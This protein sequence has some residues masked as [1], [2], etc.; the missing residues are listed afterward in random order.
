MVAICPSIRPNC[1]DP[2]IQFPKRVF[3]FTKDIAVRIW[4][5]V[6]NF[7]QNIAAAIQQTVRI[8]MGFKRIAPVQPQPPMNQAPN[9]IRIA[10]PAPQLPPAQNNDQIEDRVPRRDWIVLPNGEYEFVNLE[11]PQAPVNPIQQ[12][13]GVQGVAL[14][15]RNRLQLYQNLPIRRDPDEEGLIELY[16][17][18]RFHQAGVL[19]D[20]VMNQAKARAENL[21]PDSSIDF[22]RHVIHLYQDS[23]NA[24]D[25]DNFQQK[26]EDFHEEVL[27][28][29]PSLCIRALIFT[30]DDL[31]NKL[32]RDNFPLIL[33]DKR[34]VKGEVVR[35]PDH[36]L[37]R[38]LV[39]R[40]QFMRL[41][42]ACKKVVL[43]R[44]TVG[45]GEA[46]I[47]NEA[48]NIIHQANAIA[49]D[50]GQGHFAYD[51]VLMKTLTV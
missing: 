34:V 41:P 28:I 21:S 40:D 45:D 1:V 29:I 25:R 11:E 22:L 12:A 16:R 27:L 26:L 18:Q 15:V 23:L 19:D 9:P 17:N 6:S 14:E 37:Q 4:T 44:R 42:D 8:C 24:N 30:P 32:D 13:N 47:S 36:F 33:Q 31:Q 7:F 50:L 35:K 5:A 49:G 39:L 2:I 3:Q 48:R 38:A 10:E 46:A 51:H 43:E 20:R